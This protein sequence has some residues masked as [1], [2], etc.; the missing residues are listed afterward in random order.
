MSIGHR[1][2]WEIKSTKVVLKKEPKNIL[3]KP[4]MK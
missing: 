3:I 2:I 4:F 1:I